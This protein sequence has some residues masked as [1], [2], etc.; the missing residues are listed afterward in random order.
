MNTLERSGEL[1]N[2]LII[3]TSDNGFFHGEHR[4]PYGKLLP[5]EPSIEVPLIMRGPGRPS[6]PAPGPARGERGPR[7]HDPRGGPRQGRPR[8]SVRRALA[9]PAPRRPRARVGAGPSDRR[10]GRRRALLGPP[11]LPLRVHR[12]RRR[13]ARAVRPGARF[14]AA[15]ERARRPAL[16]PHCAGAVG[17]PGRPEDLRGRSDAARRPGWAC[18]WSPR[19]APPA[20][21][22]PGSAGA[23]RSSSRGRPTGSGSGWWPGRCG[24]RGQPIAA[25]H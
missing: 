1:D 6:R 16:L 22:G 24:E 7:A 4:I 5:Y 12:V 17:A 20:P 8:G 25:C 11:H 14:R 23:T 13:R 10:P 3:F 21:C 9:L 19:A 2:T 15:D 18:G